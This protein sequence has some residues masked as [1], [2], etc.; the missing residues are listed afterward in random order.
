MARQKTKFKIYAECITDGFSQSRKGDK[1]LLATVTSKGNAYTCMMALK[2]TYND[3]H[4]RMTL[5]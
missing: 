3:P 2:N 5:E 1:Y 4:W